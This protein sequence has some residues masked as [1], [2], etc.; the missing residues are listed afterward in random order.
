MLHLKFALNL[1]NLADNLI[2]ELTRSWNDPFLSPVVIFPDPKLEQWFRLRWIQKKGALAGFNSMMLDKFLMEILVGNDPQKKKLPT[3]MLCNVILAYLKKEEGGVANYDTL[4]DEVRRYLIIDGKLDETHLFDFATRMAT[5]FLDY[6]TSRPSNFMVSP[7]G[8]TLPGILEKWHLKDEKHPNG[9]ELFFG[10]GETSEI[11]IRERWQQKLY[12][13]IFHPNGDQDSLLNQVFQKQAERK[14]NQYVKYLTIPYLYTSSPDKN[15][16]PN[17][18]TEKF[19]DTPLFIFGLG[20]MGQFYRVLLQKFAEKHEV[21][22][23]IQNPCMEFWEDA[24]SCRNNSANICRSWQSRDGQWTSNGISVE[25]IKQKMS[26]PL[27]ANG[28]ETTVD[29]DD[30]PEYS[31]SEEGEEENQ[32]LC[33]WGRSGRENIKLWCQA[34]NYDFDFKVGYNDRMSAS[35][36]PQD[37]LLHKL[38]YSIAN[39]KKSIPDTEDAFM[40]DG[41]FD[42][43]AAPTKIREIEHI[44]TA[45]CKLLQG[46]ARISDILVVSPNL[47]NYRTAI[48]TVFDQTAVKWEGENTKEAKKG[49]LHIPFTIVDSPARNSLTENAITAMFSILE[50]GSINRPDFFELVRNPV[51]QATRHINSDEV[52]DWENWIEE[53]HVYRNRQA[54]PNDWLVGLQRLLLAKMTSHCVQ[55]GDGDNSVL[56]PYSDMASSNNASLSRFLDCIKDLEKWIAFGKQVVSCQEDLNTLSDFINDWV[57]MPNTPDAF[58]SETIIFRNASAAINNLQM[59]FDAGASSISW[60]I[61]KQSILSEAQGTKYSCGNLFVNGITF[62][63]FVPNRIIPVKHLFFIGADSRDFPGAKKQNTLDLR[64]FC[65]PWPSDDSPISKRRYAFLCQLMSVSEGFHISYINQDIKKD[66]ELYPTSI[67][68][69]IRKFLEFSCPIAKAAAKNMEDKKLWYKQSIS[70]DETRQFEDLFTPKSIRNRKAYLEMLHDGAAQNFTP[71]QDASEIQE[72][73]SHISLPDRVALYNLSSFLREPFQFRINQMMLQ[74]DEESPEKELFE[75]ISFN[76]LDESE[77]FKA[78]LAATISNQYNEFEIFRKNVTYRG[79]LPDGIFQEKLWEKIADQKATLIEKLGDELVE[80]IKTSW[81]YKEKI[82]DL[83]LERSD[84]SKW[85]LSGSLDWSNARDLD[86][87]SK[88]M[89]VSTSNVDATEIKR[90]KFMGPY[91]KALSLIMYKGVKNQKLLDTEFKIDIAIYSCS[92]VE[93]EKENKTEIEKEILQLKNGP[94]ETS[95]CMTPRQAKESLEKIYQCAFGDALLLKD[96]NP[97]GFPYCKAIPAQFI[98]DDRISSDIDEFSD[99]LLK[100]PWKYFSKKRLFDPVTDVGFTYSNFATEW[101]EAKEKMLSLANFVTTQQIVKKL[102]DQKKAEEEAEKV[103]KAAEKAQKDEA[104]KL[105]VQR[106]AE[107]KARK[108]AEKEAKKKKV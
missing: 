83:Q 97:E 78:S 27:T 70:L 59:Q 42:L 18:H 77:L 74:Y 55:T 16:E 54:K 69:D 63:N 51:V 76:R 100:E 65:K 53:T 23:F 102:E 1:E 8:H 28:E 95:V 21:F 31:N 9:M 46:G 62:M 29:I 43:T 79:A 32:L 71:T 101:K 84:G 17:F 60:K 66:A 22:A 96:R 85:I 49:Y 91:V 103:R 4:G 35:D 52:N 106:K 64:K 13:A 24:V 6:E 12:A 14:N 75:P 105:E 45:I 67:I 3:A 30:I 58:K 107:E 81:S 10:S 82:P 80:E 37:T 50:Q 25:A 108:A 5:L 33:N 90:D 94:A 15:D 99:L 47:D 7:D 87:I 44:H 39:R 98:D 41:S 40:A 92:K 11:S 61:I 19:G 88:I 73:K 36:L 56:K 68:N 38:Q 26:K 20:G 72:K 2:Q 93:P 48:K 34:A 86:K 57:S 104:K 89:S